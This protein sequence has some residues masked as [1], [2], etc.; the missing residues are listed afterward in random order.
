MGQFNDPCKYPPKKKGGQLVVAQFG[1]WNC[2]VDL[3][4]S[5]CPLLSRWLKSNKTQ[6]WCVQ[7]DEH[8]LRDMC[9]NYLLQMVIKKL[10]EIFKSGVL[11][12]TRKLT[13]FMFLKEEKA[14]TKEAL[15][16]APY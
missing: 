7:T 5:I 10:E 1:R 4:W 15:L 9:L 2:M 11:L 8:P 16:D 14:F 12:Y 13:M 6:R 3:G